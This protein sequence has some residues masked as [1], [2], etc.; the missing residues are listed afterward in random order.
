ML[1]DYYDVKR[2]SL[3]FTMQIA[4]DFLAADMHRQIPAFADAVLGQPMVCNDGTTTCR[5]YS[6]ANH[7]LADLTHL[8]LELLRFPKTSKLLDVLHQVV[9]AQPDKAEDLLDEVAAHRGLAGRDRRAGG[10]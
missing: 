2:T 7:P 8:G 3:S 6:A 5:A 1:Y 10:S 9:V 4:A